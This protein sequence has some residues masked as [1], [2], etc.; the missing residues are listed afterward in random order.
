M[1][2]ISRM[3]ILTLRFKNKRW[4]LR[5]LLRRR[6]I[7][8]LVSMNSYLILK[9]IWRIKLKLGLHRWF[10]THRFGWSNWWCTRLKHINLIGFDK[11]GR[12]IGNHISFGHEHR[13][14]LTVVLALWPKSTSLGSDNLFWRVEQAV[15]V[16]ILLRVA[17]NVNRTTGWH[18]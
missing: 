12:I 9:D 16:L 17:V 3:F 13:S 5:K 14:S 1:V 18:A 4:R 11:H 10:N 2:L 7:V 8:L 6:T 15:H